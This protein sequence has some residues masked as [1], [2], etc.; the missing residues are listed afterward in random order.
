MK[1]KYI[2][3]IIILLILIFSSFLLLYKFNNQNIVGIDE[4]KYIDWSINIFSEKAVLNY[5]R[6]VF[7]IISNLSANLFGFSY[8][9]LK[10]PNIVFFLF[11]TLLIIN[12]SKKYFQNQYFLFV[13][14]IFCVKFWSPIFL[15]WRAHDASNRNHLK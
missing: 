2:I 11:S 4:F 8:N 12:I 6:P 1:Q 15:F 13:P 14:L 5:F 9:A 10:I 3:N 7:Y